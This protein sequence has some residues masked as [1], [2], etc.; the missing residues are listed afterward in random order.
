MSILWGHTEE[1]NMFLVITFIS[2]SVVVPFVAVIG[3]PNK[4]KQTIQVVNMLWNHH[5]IELNSVTPEGMKGIHWGICFLFKQSK[6]SEA[7]LGD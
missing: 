2:K 1:P 4:G 6:D 7:A 3:V 5:V